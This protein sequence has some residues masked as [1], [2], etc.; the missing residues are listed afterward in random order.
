M[1]PYRSPFRGADPCPD[2]TPDIVANAAALGDAQLLPDASPDV[3]PDAAAVGDAEPIAFG[4]PDDVAGAVSS[5]DPASIP[6]PVIRSYALPDDIP[7]TD[8]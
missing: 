7:S 6:F 8:S 5:T 4:L 2:T 1:C 3:R